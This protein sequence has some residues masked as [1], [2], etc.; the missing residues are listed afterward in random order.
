MALGTGTI[1]TLLVGVAGVVGAFVAPLYLLVLRMYG[2]DESAAATRERLDESQSG[3]EGDITD[4]KETVHGIE[5][6]VEQNAERSQQNQEHIHQL[7][8]GSVNGN[9]DVE[10]GNPHYQPEHCPLGDECPWHTPD[11]ES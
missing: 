1:L 7:L 5:S 11:A 9:D 4:I 2:R 3:L 6:Q 8:V 10:I